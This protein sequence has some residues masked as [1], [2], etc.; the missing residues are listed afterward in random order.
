[1]GGLRLKR[2]DVLPDLSGMP[3]LSRNQGISRPIA[4]E[5]EL[6]D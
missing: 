3:K 1:M 4:G 2:V 5:P 6:I